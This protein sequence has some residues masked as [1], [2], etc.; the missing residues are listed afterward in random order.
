MSSESFYADALEKQRE[1]GLL[2]EDRPARKPDARTIDIDGRRLIDFSSNSYLGL[3]FRLRE[4]VARVF[5]ELG[6]PSS[7][8]SSRMV[9]GTWPLH[10]EFERA[11]ADFLGMES[12]ALFGAGFL[13][14]A[15]TIAALASSR[16]MIFFDA[17]CHASLRE[18]IRMSQ[19]HAE[20][21]AHADADDLEK[22]L[23]AVNVP[24]RRFIVTDGLFS[25]DGDFAPLDRIVPLAERFDAM[26]IVDDAHALGALGESGR[27]TFERFGMKPAPNHV[28]LGTLS[29]TFGSF[30]GFVAAQETVIRYIKARSRLFIYTTSLPPFQVL[31]AK[32]ALEIITSG[33]GA[34][35]RKRLAENVSCLASALNRT[36]DS[37]IVPIP[38]AGG[39]DAV[40]RAADHLR[41]RGLFAVGM[42]YP[43][44]PRGRDMIRVSLSAAHTADDIA[45]LASELSSLR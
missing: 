33:D 10:L 15:G 27:G 32:L 44:V 5:Q 40:M 28:V 25:M 21:Y 45:K 1:A 3:N 36:F 11:L 23:A 22:K 2:R 38:I 35:L 42:R 29:K 30:G 12:A 34:K 13:G 20:E 17:A 8:G 18:G 4:R 39:P 31:A 26:L 43:T 41:E 7:T 24:G 9:S 16:D 14:C 19:A 6:L 37:P